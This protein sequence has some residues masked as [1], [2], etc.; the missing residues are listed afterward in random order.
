MHWSAEGEQRPDLGAWLAIGRHRKRDPLR[1]PGW[2]LAS[3]GRPCRCTCA[4]ACGRAHTPPRSP[5][6]T[7]GLI[8]PAPPLRPRCRGRCLEAGRSPFCTPTEPQPPC[9]PRA[10]ASAAPSSWRCC[11]GG[12]VHVLPRHGPRKPCGHC[13]GGSNHQ[14]AGPKVSAPPTAGIGRVPPE[15]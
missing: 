10:T 9:R 13:G 11:H 3:V 2:A 8:I 15:F 14:S 6:H 1:G 5:G 4:C 12:E 7:T